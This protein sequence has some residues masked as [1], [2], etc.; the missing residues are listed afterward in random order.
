[1]EMIRKWKSGAGIV[2]VLALLAAESALAQF[3][4]TP[5][6]TSDAV[7]QLG[8]IGTAV[9]AIGGGL[10]IAGAIAVAFK[11]AKAALFG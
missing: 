4:P 9:A 1:M 10:L 8:E 11:W 3:T 7:A 5:V 2:A 6:D